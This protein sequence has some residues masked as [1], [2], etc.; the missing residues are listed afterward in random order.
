M[1]LSKRQ[2]YNL[3]KKLNKIMQRLEKLEDE[4]PKRQKKWLRFEECVPP[5]SVCKD[6]NSMM[7]G[8][9]TFTGFLG[10]LAEYYGCEEM[11][12]YVDKTI[13][14]KYVAV[15]HPNLKEARSRT[16]HVDRKTVLHEWFHHLVNLRVVIVSK[17]EEEKYANLYAD[18][19]LAR[20]NS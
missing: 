3:H 16:K 14:P 5:A 8:N 17:S 4:I 12:I 11:P 10:K 2:W 19:F 9:N 7:E 20:A 6:I 13:N 15:Y 18:V 1:E